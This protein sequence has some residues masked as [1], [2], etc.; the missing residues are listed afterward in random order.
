[1][2]PLKALRDSPYV[3][4]PLM[5]PRTDSL[6]LV[7][8]HQAEIWRYLR[9]L[10]CRGTDAEDLT[11][12][13]FLA[14]LRKPF[15]DRGPLASAGYLRRVARNLFLKSVHRQ[16]R[17]PALVDLEEAEQVWVRHCARDGGERYL[18]SLR[19]CVG[20]LQTRGRQAVSLRY[21]QGR[22]R[23]QIA[24]LLG[25]TSD[26]VKALLRRLR[27]SLRACVERKIED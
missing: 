23:S 21:H 6:A 13:T 7:H 2:H 4:A 14:V 3:P 24:E 25:M 17:Q 5:L 1:M 16:S 11:Q 19:E 8:A 15:E 18:D 22:S 12:E 20:E 26:G 9:F 10:G 27:Q